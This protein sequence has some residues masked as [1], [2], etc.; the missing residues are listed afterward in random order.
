M[1]VAL[2][3]VAPAST[4]ATS[5]AAT[6]PIYGVSLPEG[7]RQWQLVGVAQET[8]ALNELRAVVGNATALQAYQT[9]TLPFPDGTVLVKLAWKHE[10]SSEF[11]PAFVPGADD[12]PGHGQGLEALCRNRRLGARPLHRR[13]AGGPGAAPHLLRL[14]QRQRPGP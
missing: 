3:R 5:T 13:Q 9:G 7:Y 10:Q 1:A 4:A 14:P 12:G 6:S 2:L 11:A 8:G